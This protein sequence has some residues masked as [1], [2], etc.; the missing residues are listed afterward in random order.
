MN[1]YWKL[2]NYEIDRF[3]RIYGAMAILTLLLQSAAAAWLARSLVNRIRD[4]LIAGSGHSF[5]TFS[6]NPLFLAPVALCA[7]ALILYVFLIWYRDWFGRHT[8]IYRLLLLPSS[9]MNVYWAKLSAIF[10]FVLGLIALQLA[11]LPLHLYTF[12]AIVPEEYRTAADVA[13]VIRK[14][15]LFILLIPRYAS[16]Y[17]FFYGLGLAGLIVAFT[18]ILLERSYRIRGLIAGI[19]YILCV[20]FLLVTPSV[21]H[22]VYPYFFYFDELNWMTCVIGLLIV[23]GSLWLS[24]YLIRRKITV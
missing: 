24:S 7:A 13:A 20:V 6:T 8:F 5:T 10:L 12:Q 14:N 15:D 18:V 16:D 2:L 1:A 23:C 21:I 4:G 22:E 17:I 11:T 9:R 19:L 3:S